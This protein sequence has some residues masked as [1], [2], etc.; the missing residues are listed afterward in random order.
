MEYLDCDQ[1]LIIDLISKLKKENSNLKKENNTLK[2]KND[3]LKKNNNL[4]K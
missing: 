1:T 2:I 4:E 3:K